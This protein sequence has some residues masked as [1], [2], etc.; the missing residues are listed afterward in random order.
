MWK[1]GAFGLKISTFPRLLVVPI[2][3]TYLV[4]FTTSLVASMWNMSA[5]HSLALIRSPTQKFGMGLV[6]KLQTMHKLTILVT[7]FQIRRV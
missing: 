5:A 6:V 7:F 3:V 2:H 1:L 4:A